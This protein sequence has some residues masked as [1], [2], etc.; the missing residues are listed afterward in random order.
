MNI[1][2]GIE[3]LESRILD[4]RTGLP[5]EIFLFVSRIT[6]LVNVD[7][8][9]RNEGGKTL[10]TWRNDEQCGTGW[11]VPGGIVRFQET[12]GQRIQLVAKQELG[13]EVS[14][15]EPA[16]AI[17]EIIR[18]SQRNR[19]HFISFLY[20]CELLNQLPADR[21]YHDGVPQNGQW[22]WHESCPQNILPIHRIYDKFIEAER[23]RNGFYTSIVSSQRD[24]TAKKESIT[25]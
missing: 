17:H 24:G 20:S 21:Q 19:G 2:E 13:V 23:N 5:E 1:L 16:I 15:R 3:I 22:C 14:Y 9:I 7:L 8:L 11:H 25:T 4:A 12:I 10:L 18:P 6:P